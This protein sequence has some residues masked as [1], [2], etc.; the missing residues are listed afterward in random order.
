MVL[1]ELIKEDLL[2][3]VNESWISIKVLG[4]FK[5]NFLSLIL[6]YLIQTLLKIS[7]QYNCATL[8]KKS[9]QK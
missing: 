4:V 8:L 6:K 9:S 7:G 5:T 3:V 2:A 1:Y